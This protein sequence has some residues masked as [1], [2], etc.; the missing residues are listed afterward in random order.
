M[1][2]PIDLVFYC[3]SVGG[4]SNHSNE[5]SA[6]LPQPERTKFRR[7]MIA[8]LINFHTE[9]VMRKV[10]GRTLG[11]II[12]LEE[13]FEQVPIARG[14]VDGVAYALYPGTSKPE[15]QS[16]RADGDAPKAS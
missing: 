3:D 12:A 16:E 1:S 14:V 7:K 10:N 11:E 8:Y 6:K 13:H 4:F 9:E 5:I 15:D 2:N